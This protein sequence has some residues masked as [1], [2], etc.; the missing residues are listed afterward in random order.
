M[1]RN[2]LSLAFAVLCAVVTLSSCL[3]NDNPKPEPLTP[4]QLRIRHIS[5]CIYRFKM[6]NPNERYY[7][8]REVKDGQVKH[9][10]KALLR[11]DTKYYTVIKLDDPSKLPAVDES[12]GIYAAG[13]LMEDTKKIIHRG[14][15]PTEKK[16]DLDALDKQLYW[17]VTKHTAVP[18]SKISVYRVPF[19]LTQANE[20]RGLTDAICV[21][22]AKPEN[23][24][25]LKWYSSRLLLDIVA[26]SPTDPLLYV[27]SAK[28]SGISP[29]LIADILYQDTEV[30]Q[31]AYPYFYATGWSIYHPATR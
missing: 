21:R 31:D 20:E 17:V 18:D 16:E 10:Q 22:L 12:K 13:K 4:E 5:N 26:Q 29:L 15:R 3:G 28:Y 7:W 6:G 14:S 27:V 19:Y 1:K 30:F 8:I 23:I 24:E 11:N 2:I 25:L 9:L